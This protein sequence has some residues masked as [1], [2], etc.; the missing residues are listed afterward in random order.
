MAQTP[1]RSTIGAPLQRGDIIHLGPE[2]PS[3]VPGLEEVRVVATAGDRIVVHQG[4]LTVNGKEVEGLSFAFL[5][6]LPP[7]G[8]DEKLTDG[9][10]L[11]IFDGKGQGGRIR[12]WG[13]T[14]AK[15]LLT[16][17]A[18][19]IPGRLDRSSR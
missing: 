15:A 14:R 6:A 18:A 17:G 1:A 4:L 10:V 7:K 9:S 16:P 19:V 12:Y 8:V 3:V 13:V 11:V 5:D 2:F